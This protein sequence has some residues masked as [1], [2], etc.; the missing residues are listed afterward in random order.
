MNENKPKPLQPGLV[1]TRRPGESFV[2]FAGDDEIEISVSEVH[3]KTVKIRILA[4]R[5]IDI[6][7]TE[8]LEWYDDEQPRS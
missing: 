8:N 6:E 4:P 1:L 7:R 5:H 3:G 2:C